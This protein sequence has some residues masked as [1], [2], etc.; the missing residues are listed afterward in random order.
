MSDYPTNQELTRRCHS[1]LLVVSQR[2]LQEFALIHMVLLGAEREFTIY[3]RPVGVGGWRP[4]QA[5]K[6]SWTFE[7][8][9]R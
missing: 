5:L 8:G 7:P 9:A 2:D 1:G 6:I 3:S 4:R